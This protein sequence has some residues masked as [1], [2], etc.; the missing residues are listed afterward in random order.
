[1]KKIIQ[2]FAVLSF[3]VLL[4]VGAASA[5]S[6]AKMK[7]DLP[8]NFNLG[9]QKLNAG[10]YKIEVTRN[11]AGVATV[12]FIDGSGKVR[13][14]VLGITSGKSSPEQAKLLFAWVGNGN[15]LSDILL[16]NDGISLNV[17]RPKRQVTVTGRNG[18]PAAVSLASIN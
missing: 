1:M 11:L 8:F 6:T 10:V 3:A 2:F 18:G 13:R 17:S 7:A 12:S 16:E 5:Q 14:T 9:K 4:G 15:S